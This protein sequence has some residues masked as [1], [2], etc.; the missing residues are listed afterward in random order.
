MSAL[1]KR[2]KDSQA[3]VAGGLARESS[4]AV[5]ALPSMVTEYLE[6]ARGSQD[7]ETLRKAVD[8]LFRMAMAGLPPSD[9]KAHLATIHFTFG[10]GGVRGEVVDVPARVVDKQ[11]GDGDV[12]ELTNPFEK[13]MPKYVPLEP[14]DVTDGSFDL[15]NMLKGARAKE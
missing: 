14:L 13:P 4:R 11:D 1:Q 8:F 15:S 7:A 10:S 12:V 6:V 3:H 5:D 9:N 2:I